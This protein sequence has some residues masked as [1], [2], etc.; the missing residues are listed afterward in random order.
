MLEEAS[1]VLLS[2]FFKAFSN[3]SYDLDT[4]TYIQ[5]LYDTP[6]SIQ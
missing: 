5:Q 3:K 1:F 2:K 4:F 6:L